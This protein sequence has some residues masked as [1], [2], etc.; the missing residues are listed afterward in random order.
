VSRLVAANPLLRVSLRLI[1]SDKVR[2]PFALIISPNV[3][4]LL[5]SRIASKGRIAF[6]LHLHLG[7]SAPSSPIRMRELLGLDND[8]LHVPVLGLEKR[9]S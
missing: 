7:H 3:F 2:L 5:D 6:F 8:K 1:R 4:Y 9:H